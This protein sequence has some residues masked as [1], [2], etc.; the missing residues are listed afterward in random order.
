MSN[1]LKYLL[2][3]ILPVI[4]FLTVCL[5]KNAIGAYYL[6]FED[7]SYVYLINSLNVSL[8]F[9]VGHFD[10]P[11]TTVQVV[12]AAVI[13][14]YHRISS[15]NPDLIRDVLMRPEEYLGQINII[16]ILMGSS[17]LLMLGIL[18]Y[19]LSGNIMLS[20]LMQLSPFVSL[21]I[22]YGLKIVASDN[23]LV[24]VSL[25]FTGMLIYY[26]YR[27]KD[28]AKTPLPFILIFAVICAAGLATKIS[29]F[30]MLLI[31]LLL[32]KGTRSRLVF[33]IIVPL[34]FLIFVIPA[35]SNYEKFLEWVW[36]LILFNGSYGHGDP[37]VVDVPKFFTS[38]TS[39]FSGDPVFAVSY[40]LSVL[41]LIAAYIKSKN[42]EEL[43]PKQKKE[44]KLLL[45]IVL[46]MTIQ[47]LI[48]AK[49]YRQHYMIPS[50]IL[51][52]FSFT[53]CT[54]LIS[55]FFDK[56][57]LQTL[58]AGLIIVISITAFFKISDSYY[59]TLFF[60][61]EAIKV[62]LYVKEKNSD[63]LCISSFGSASK[64]F[65]LAYGISYS[66][67]KIKSYK[68]I[69]SEIQKENIFY[70]PWQDGLFSLSSKDSTA[71]TLNENKKLLFQTNQD[72]VNNFIQTIENKYGLKIIDKK[73]LFSNSINECVY[74]I[75][76]GSQNENMK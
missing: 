51:S 22:F 75:T 11:G 17:V 61:D 48:V 49:Q 58:Y 15:S 39:I 29:F 19:K 62:N 72:N 45:S 14:I 23:F 30:P 35:I 70:I 56:L 31:P 63:A 32:I 60:R 1:K 73:L 36:M 5:L 76:K 18:T 9:P 67:Y 64:E 66:G 53:L 6:N 42:N 10:H 2:L 65:S 13:R 59:T 38:L 57:K 3:L 7:P 54:Q 24:T 52:I 25:C 34:L 50:L 40:F 12:G 20:L 71:A 44:F 55:S 27:I 8:R 26:L 43:N 4:L 46:A 37:S 33:L 68:S 41:T 21:Q 47:V 69:L 16:L 74:E 28:E